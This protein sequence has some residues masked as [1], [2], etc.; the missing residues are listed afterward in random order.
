MTKQQF[1]DAITIVAHCAESERDV[2]I[3]AYVKL[4]RRSKQDF[5]QFTFKNQCL[6]AWQTLQDQEKDL[7][8]MFFDNSKKEAT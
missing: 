5:N 6:Q 8:N 4:F 3:D 2:T 7:F 1:R